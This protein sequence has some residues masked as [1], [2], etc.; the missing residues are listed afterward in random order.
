[1]RYFQ[2]VRNMDLEQA[3]FG[4]HNDVMVTLDQFENEARE[5][6]IHSIDNFM[7]SQMFTEHFNVDNRSIT[8]RSF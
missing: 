1:M 3:V 7:K 8:K 2:V 4:D 6:G 5:I